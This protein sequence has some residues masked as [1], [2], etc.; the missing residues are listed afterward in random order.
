MTIQPTDREARMNELIQKAK[1]WVM[2]QY[3]RTCE[4]DWLVASPPNSYSNLR[5]R[6]TVFVWEGSPCKGF[7]TADYGHGFVIAC[8]P[9][10]VRKFWKA[11]YTEF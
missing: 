1:N 6:V 10:G 5:Y 11:G 8:N 9:W 3:G 4:R 7:V 2:D